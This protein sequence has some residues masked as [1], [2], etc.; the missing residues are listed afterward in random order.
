MGSREPIALLF[1]ITPSSTSCFLLTTFNH[2]ITKDSLQTASKKGK[3][4]L[5]LHEKHAIRF[6]K[7]PIN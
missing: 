7:L 2:I 4:A 3:P 1:P 6:D 5:T